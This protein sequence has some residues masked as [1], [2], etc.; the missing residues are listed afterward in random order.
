MKQ[1]SWKHPNC[2]YCIINIWSSPW[3]YAEVGR[4][5]NSPTL[6]SH[7][8]TRPLKSLYYWISRYWIPPKSNPLGLSFFAHRVQTM[9]WDNYHLV[10]SISLTYISRVLY[11]KISSPSFR[12][13]AK[14]S[15]ILVHRNRLNQIC[16]INFLTMPGHELQQK[17]RLGFRLKSLQ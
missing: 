1:H 3:N 15:C 9:L 14:N 6:L 4:M 11:I 2:V 12:K 10:P 16:S 5:P 8:V 17:T 13:R 7:S